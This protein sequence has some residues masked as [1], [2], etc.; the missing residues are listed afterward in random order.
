MR[1]FLNYVSELWV[2][3]R[4]TVLFSKIKNSR[5]MSIEFKDI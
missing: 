1:E 2:T 3:D 4:M 5:M